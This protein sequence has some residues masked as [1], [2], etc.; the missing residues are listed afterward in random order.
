VA[1]SLIDNPSPSLP[2]PFRTFSTTGTAFHLNYDPDISHTPVDKVAEVFGIP[3]LRSALADFLSWWANPTRYGADILIGGCWLARDDAYLPCMH[4]RVWYS[5]KMQRKSR[6]R[7]G[8]PP[9][10]RKV[11]A[12]LAKSDGYPAWPVGRFDPVILGSSKQESSVPTSTG[13]GLKGK[14]SIMFADLEAKRA[15]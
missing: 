3:D 7:E 1:Q 9:L 14:Y 6:D 10:S 13:P 8:E 15:G 12:L 4:L 11:M 2:H 5:F